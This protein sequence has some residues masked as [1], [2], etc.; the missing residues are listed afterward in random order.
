MAERFR[1]VITPILTPYNDDFSIAEDLYLA[2]AGACLAGGAHYISPFGTTSEALSQ[3][4]RERMAM[5]EL[6]AS[7]GT[8]RP[9]QMMPGTGLCNME[10]T[11]TLCRHAVEL[12]CAAVM[13]LP[14]FFFVN[15]GDEG[16]YRYFSGL[17]ESVGSDRL[18]VCLYHIPQMAGIGV[19][20]G[21][22]A[23]LNAAF[24]EVVVAY[25]D[26]SGNWENTK[27][28]IEAAPGISVFPGSESYLV[29]AVKLGGG[30]CI[31]ASCNSNVA[32]IRG[33]YDLAA[34]G[35]WEAAA[36]ALGPVNVHRKAVQ[37]GGLI[38]A[39][40]AL[41]A[42]QSGDARWLNLRPPLENADPA[43]GERLAATL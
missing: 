27:A 39:L 33:V 8:A 34:A 20:P 32:A 7:S 21:L 26:S 28:V 13:T 3:S 40:K 30:G 2:H 1:G 11:A 12:G 19:S 5:V 14:P 10:E 15:A 9:G 37:D 18:K 17:I 24:P 6:L 16:L 4:M 22:A 29:D 36:A 42:Y 31:S 35:K 25:K 43:L 23:R 41:K 38:P